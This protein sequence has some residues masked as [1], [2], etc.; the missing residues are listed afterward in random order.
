MKTTIVIEDVIERVRL[1]NDCEAELELIRKAYD[2][3][4][5]MHYGVKRLTGEDYI[6]HPLNVAYILTDVQADTATICAGLLHDVLEDCDITKEELAKA[7]TEEIANLVD[8]V[9]KI[10]RLNFD[11]VTSATVAT[12]RKILVGLCEDVRVIIIKLADRLHNMRTLWVHS[13]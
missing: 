7:F 4:Y 11:S 6:D 9:T 8:G 1:Y 3:A 13:E 5:Q 10:N 12:H 2:Y